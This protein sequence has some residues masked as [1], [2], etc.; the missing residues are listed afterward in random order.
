MEL[1][2]NG[3]LAVTEAGCRQALQAWSMQIAFARN[4]PAHTDNMSVSSSQTEAFPDRCR[5]TQPMSAAKYLDGCAVRSGH[6]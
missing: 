6:T 3:V 2:H 5:Q 1:V 4:L